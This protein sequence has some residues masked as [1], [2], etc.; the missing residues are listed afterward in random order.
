MKRLVC[1]LGISA[2][3][4]VSA[5]AIS[6]DAEP[7]ESVRTAI[8]KGVQY[9]KTHQRSDGSWQYSSHDLGITSLVGLALAENGVSIEDPVLKRAYE[10]VQAHAANQVQTYDISLAILFLV[11]IGKA[12]DNDLIQLLGA[13]LAAGQLSSGG[14]TYNCP[15]VIPSSP[16]PSLSNKPATKS[17]QEAKRDGKVAQRR[18][19]LVATGRAAGF[20]DNSNTQFAVLGIWAAGQV[21]LDVTEVL[22]NVDGR[23]RTTQAGSGGWGYNAPGADTPAMT[24]AGLMA[25]ILA[26]GQKTLEAQMSNQP[27][28][29]TAPEGPGGKPKMASDN[30]IDRGIGRV[31]FYAS[32]LNPQT[33]HYFLW[34]LER[35]GVA[36]GT[37]R[38][39]RVDWYSTGTDLLIRSQNAD[40]SWRS[41]HGEFS[42]TSFAL[43]FLR[44]S[45]LTK[46]MP[47]LV[48]NR[49][50][51]TGETRLRAGTLDD[52]LKTVRSPKEPPAAD[53]DNPKTKP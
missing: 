31:E 10:F 42:D 25:L 50:G 30:Q 4:L 39:G 29:A 40:G 33:N 1:A 13:R 2:V 36:L 43:L 5:A 41:A 32:R 18:G 44:R 24:C 8:R 28:D 20:G 52:L 45:N 9:L 14:W 35:V 48:T 51:D 15:Q 22:A 19:N 49:G 21:G 47:Q 17:K 16:S 38:I 23:F 3:A 12:T 37:A 26:K 11:R 27:P 53:A 46:G 34:S 6:Q 7:D